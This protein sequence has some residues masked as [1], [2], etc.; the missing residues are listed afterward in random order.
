MKNKT[1]F[2]ISLTKQKRKKFTRNWEGGRRW[3]VE[4]MV[5]VIAHPSALTVYYNHVERSL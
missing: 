4:S 5:D 1:Q 3:A 2:N